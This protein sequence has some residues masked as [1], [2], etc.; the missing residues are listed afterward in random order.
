MFYSVSNKK[1]SVKQKESF[2]IFSFNNNID[3]RSLCGLC[4]FDNFLYASTNFGLD[5]FVTP[6]KEISVGLIANRA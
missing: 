1:R 5:Q 2:L 3:V 6:F 4:T